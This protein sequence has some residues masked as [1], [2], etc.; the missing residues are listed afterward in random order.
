MCYNHQVERILWEGGE[1]SYDAPM[2]SEDIMKWMKKQ[3]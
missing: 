2:Q 3:T 1:E